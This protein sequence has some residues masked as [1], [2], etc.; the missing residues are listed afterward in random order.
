MSINS[1]SRKL[2]ILFMLHSERQKY[3][4][5][6]NIKIKREIFYIF[7]TLYNMQLQIFVYIFN[8]IQI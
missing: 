7:I 8:I 3:S 2:Y 1:I 5:S 6:W 4:H